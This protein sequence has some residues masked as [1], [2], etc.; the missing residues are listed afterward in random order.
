MNVKSMARVKYSYNLDGINLTGVTTSNIVNTEVRKMGLLARKFS[1]SEFYKTGDIISFNIVVSNTGNYHT[2]NIILE[3]TIVGQE[4]IPS[5]VKYY[6]L[7][8]DKDLDVS[9]EI[10]D[11]LLKIKIPKLDGHNIC[12]ISYKTIISTNL[13]SIK[14]ELKLYSDEIEEIVSKPFD[15]K[16]G[17]ARIECYKKVNDNVTFLNSNLTYELTLKNTGNIS[18]YNVE[19]YDE[20]PSTYSLDLSNPVIYD[21]NRLDYELNNNILTFALPEVPA[22]SEVTVL[23][24]GR[25]TK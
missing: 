8:D 24:N 14:S 10:L 5:T 6:L 15:L 1:S 16:Q 17:F 22:Q 23:V 25:I 12:V 7:D 13:Q 3:D 9:Y 19:V 20:L 4:L 2:N 11:N 21:G 18:A